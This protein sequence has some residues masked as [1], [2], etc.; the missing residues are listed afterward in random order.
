MVARS[1]WAAPLRV[2]IDFDR[3]SG[4]FEYVLYRSAEATPLIKTV[5]ARTY[6]FVGGVL[7]A[8][9]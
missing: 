5:E 2:L 4:G 9:V 3:C 7:K 8:D 6:R 1:R